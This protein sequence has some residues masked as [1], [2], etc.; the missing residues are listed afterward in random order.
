MPFTCPYPRSIDVIKHGPGNECSTFELRIERKNDVGLLF[1]DPLEESNTKFLFIPSGK[2]DHISL[3]HVKIPA[4]TDKYLIFPGIQA[5]SLNVKTNN[6]LP[7]GSMDLRNIR[8][9]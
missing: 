8:R 5:G 4:G 7:E 6:F 1:F 2:R 3:R 9:R